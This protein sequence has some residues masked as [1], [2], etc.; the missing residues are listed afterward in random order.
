MGG[1]GGGRQGSGTYYN[2]EGL[3][4]TMEDISQ[5]VGSRKTYYNQRNQ[6]FATKNL[7][8]GCGGLHNVP[9]QKD[10]VEMLVVISPSWGHI[11]ASRVDNLTEN[12][13][14]LHA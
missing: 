6:P 7:V 8:G 2:Q 14:Y 3:I 12:D 11:F 1:L 4:T 13:T 10:L 5:L 9:V